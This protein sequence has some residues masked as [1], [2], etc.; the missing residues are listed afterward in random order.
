[1]KILSFSLVLLI[2]VI[3]FAQAQ[4]LQQ[5]QADELLNRYLELQR[6]NGAVLMAKNQKILFQKGYGLADYEHNIPIDSTT[7]F[8]ITGISE[9]LTAYIAVKVFEKKGLSI[10]SP[11]GTWLGDSKFSRADTITLH[12]LLTHTS[13]LPDYPLIHELPKQQLFAREDLL[14]YLAG[15]TPEG[16]LGKAYSYS[17]LNFNLTGLIVEQISNKSFAQLLKEL[18]TEP[19][20][21]PNTSLDDGACIKK[22]S[23]R[24]YTR[25]NLAEGWI[26]APYLHPA[27]TFAAQGVLSTPQDLLIWQHY[28]KNNY[29][30]DKALQALLTSPHA[31][32]GYGFRVKRNGAGKIIALSSTAV[33]AS[34]FNSFSS[35]D[36]E[37]GTITIVL[38]NNRNPASEDIAAGLQAIFNNKEYTLPLPRKIVKVDPQSLQKLA[39]SY[40]INEHMSLKIMVEGNKVF[41]DNG[42]HPKFRIFPQS[43]LQFFVEATDAEIVFIT[44]KEGRIT[45]LGLRNDGFTNA[46]AERTN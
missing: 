42:M 35:I 45:R 40:M 41:V 7:K 27:N 5:Q 18:V 11:I 46:F 29:L 24:G 17:K 22:R 15:I 13:G 38:G 26:N 4:H 21:M 43:S 31:E 28:I 25:R 20:G 19:I 2:S 33:Y 3:S 6:F 9:Q 30:K 32:T 36:L 14:P 16:R 34:G 10:N 23:A 12:H 39:G 37:S 44:N 1:M 8:Y